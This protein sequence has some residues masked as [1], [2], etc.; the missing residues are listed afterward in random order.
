MRVHLVRL[1]RTTAAGAP[2]AGEAVGWPAP[3]TMQPQLGAG[4]SEHLEKIAR[5]WGGACTS[6]PYGYA[7]NSIEIG[8]RRDEPGATPIRVSTLTSN[9]NNSNSTNNTNKAKRSEANETQSKAEQS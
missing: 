6:A 5:W 2:R 8:H 1:A 3:P 4:C 9:A 7:C